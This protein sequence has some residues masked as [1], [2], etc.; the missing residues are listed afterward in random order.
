MSVATES[1]FHGK[2]DGLR[3]VVPIYERLQP[4]Y[5]E[6]EREQLFRRAWLPVVQAAEVPEQGSYTVVEMPT[7][8]TSLLVMRGRDGR[9]RAFHNLCRHRGNELVRAGKGYRH[10]HSCG[11][12]GWSFSSEGALVGVTDEQQFPELDKAQLGLIPVHAELWAGM[13]FVNFEATPRQSLREWLGELY[14]GYQG[15]FD[16]MALVGSTRAEIACNWHMAVN[17]FTEGYHT[18]FI[19][20]NTAPDYQGGARNPN[21]HRPFMQLM[22]RHSRFS[23]PSNP[24]RRPTP[25]EAIAYRH[26]RPL[27]PAAG[28]Q[29]LDLPP[30]VNPSRTEHW[31]FDNVHL[32]PNFV[33]LTGNHWVRKLWFWP[34]DAG[35][36]V[37]H[38]EV[39]AYRARTAGDRLGQAY[40]RARGRE[41]AREDMSTL[42]A[43]QAALLSGAMETMVLSRQEMA[44]QHHYRVADALMAVD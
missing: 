30:G 4:A 20:R 6:R 16:G 24:D 33:M 31:L 2:L 10:V 35:R 37:V 41:V 7:F 5:F 9:V 44:L 8:K 39:Y 36:T 14:D 15:Y 29:G 23:A 34:I 38:R 25:V 40:F 28:W 32:F 3:S 21:R 13:V 18:L 43:C 42:E 17:A 19:H 26:S 1:T 12:H 22:E 11:F 27:L